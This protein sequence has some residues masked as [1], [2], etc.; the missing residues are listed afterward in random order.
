[1]SQVIK[2]GD[3]GNTVSVDN[4]NRMKTLSTSADISIDSAL[5]GEAFFLTS[6]VVEL[7]SSSQSHIFYMKNTDSVDWVL[8]DFNTVI[9][10][11]IGAPDIEINTQFTINPNDGTLI[12]AG[13]VVIPANL[14]FG[15]SKSL[16]GTFRK[17]VEGSTISG[18][19]A[20]PKNMY[21]PNRNNTAALANPL[22]IAP[23]TGFAFAIEPASDNTSLK[24]VFNATLYRRVEP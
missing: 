24:V 10:Q 22:I 21:L 7:T 1:M 14:N 23:G 2:S 9:N 8:R 18:G 16:N 12:T 11:S 3:S 13:G 15:S 20:V 19:I 5:Q 4:R 17:G 6:G